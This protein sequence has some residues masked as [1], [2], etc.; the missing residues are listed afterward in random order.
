VPTELPRRLLVIGGGPIGCEL[1]QAF[2]RFGASVT[3]VEQASHLLPREDPAAAAVV[4]RALIRD[5]V[6]L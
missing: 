5:G 2:A 1:A 6:A 4:Q 3:I